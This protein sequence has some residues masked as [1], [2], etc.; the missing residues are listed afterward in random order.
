MQDSLPLLNLNKE[1]A[2]RFFWVE[3]QWPMIE[4]PMIA[5]W[6]IGF[7]VN[8]CGRAGLE[9]IFFRDLQWQMDICVTLPLLPQF[10]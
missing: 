2:S 1:G 6:S 4:D 5:D 9:E 3:S 8:L 7:E 10:S